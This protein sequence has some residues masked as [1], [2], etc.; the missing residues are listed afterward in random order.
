VLTDLQIKKLAFPSKRREI[1]DGRVRGLYLVVQ[2]SGAKS[3]AVRYR[4]GGKPRKLTLGSYPAV[5]LAAARRRAE[6]AIGDVAG[7][8]DPAALKRASKAALR[9]ER[10]VQADVVERVAASFLDRYVKRNVGPTWGREIER[11]LK[12]EIIPWIGD[13]RLGQ[14]KKSDVHNLLDAIVDRGS[15]ITANRTFAVVR[16]LCNWATEREIIPCS[17]AIRSSPP[18]LKRAATAF[19]TITKSVWHGGPSKRSAGRSARSASFSS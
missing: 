3:W 6:E 2:P 15:P 19:W 18:R 7:G 16:Q 13:R 8:K 10:E 11:L 1:P 9:A 12:V 17:P 5:D 4:T 14:L